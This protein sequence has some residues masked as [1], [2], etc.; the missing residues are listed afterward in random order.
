M[1]S[2][3]AKVAS[4]TAVNKMTS[5]NLG[6]VF[7]PALLRRQT[8]TPQQIIRD[9]PIVIEIV[10]LMVDSV[11]VFF[12]GQELVLSPDATAPLPSVGVK[13]A[14]DATA[15][16]A[17]DVVMDEASPRVPP[18]TPSPRRNTGGATHQMLASAAV[19]IVNARKDE[20][21]SDRLTASQLVVGSA[22]AG[23]PLAPPAWARGQDRK[24]AAPG[25]PAPKNNFMQLGRTGMRGNSPQKLPGQPSPLG[26]AQPVSASAELESTSPPVGV[27][28]SPSGDSE[29]KEAED[30]ALRQVEDL[31]RSREAEAKPESASQNLS[32][33]VSGLASLSVSSTAGQR[34]SINR[35]G[36]RYCTR[37]CFYADHPMHRNR[38]EW[39]RLNQTRNR[40]TQRINSFGHL[41]AAAMELALATSNNPAA[42]D[43]SM[44]IDAY[45]APELMPV[46]RPP[47]DVS[48]SLL[49][50]VAE[51][52]EVR[53]LLIP[54]HFTVSWQVMS[55]LF[56]QS[57]L[58]PQGVFT[59]TLACSLCRW[60]QRT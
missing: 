15:Q 44:P 3:L 13:T 24:P 49:M 33:S 40:L 48:T 20:P 14:T 2:Y 35:R 57:G 27:G 32:Q 23:G 12:K 51:L 34:L 59:L 42:A 58:H 47:G 45:G 31:L 4:F 29:A 36:S 25:A 26:I 54:A 39:A 1:R 16:V 52:Q 8:E 28:V 56:L 11:Q 21:G 9:S 17:S 38:L 7:G 41:E 10:T 50:P 60:W 55:C 6:I 18:V 43:D 22:P 37:A 5:K 53:P 46:P 19:A 30:D